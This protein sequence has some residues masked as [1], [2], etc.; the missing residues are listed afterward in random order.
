MRRDLIGIIR[1]FLGSSLLK[2]T[3]NYC[4]RQRFI[5]VFISKSRLRSFLALL[6]YNTFFFSV[7]PCDLSGFE[8]R[9]W[10]GSNSLNVIYVFYLPWWGLRLGVI[11]VVEGWGYVSN[12]SEF[13]GGTI[14]PE[15]EFSEMLGVNFLYKW[16]ARRL[17]VDYSF[18]GVPLLKQFPAVG[19]EE[20]E[21]D[22]YLR[23]L[24]YRGVKLQ[25]G[26][27]VYKF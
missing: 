4:S 25:N 19:F 2:V 5:Y 18:E 1:S 7:T 15:R 12:A 16:D 26:L 20:L 11:S 24:F 3:D 13:F 23:W 10:L 27:E 6:R 22:F 17:M 14:W 9:R 8:R 21:Y